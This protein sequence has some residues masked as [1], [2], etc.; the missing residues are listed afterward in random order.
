MDLQKRYRRGNHKTI[1][2]IKESLIIEERYEKTK[3][4][5]KIKLND[6]KNKYWAMEICDFDSRINESC[7]WILMVNNIYGICDDDTV[8]SY[9]N[10]MLTQHKKY[11]VASDEKSN[12][13]MA[14]ALANMKVNTLEV[15]EE[16][17][18]V[19]VDLFIAVLDPKEL[20]KLTRQLIAVTEEYG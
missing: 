14:L 1:D 18:D 12:L 6:I 2:K 8:I 5:S 4:I 19:I 9:L 17:G 20:R 3:D 15:R 16:A 13:V 11:I 7:Q 10:D